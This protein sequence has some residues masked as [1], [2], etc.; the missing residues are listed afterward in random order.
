M[1]PFENAERLISVF[2]RWPSFHDAEI[3]RI[4]LERGGPDGPS[5]A[6]QIHV[7]AMT[8]EV[9]ARGYY[10]SKNHTLTTLRFCRIRL[11]ELTDFNHQNVIFDLE[12]SEIDPPSNEG[13]RFHVE[14]GTSYGCAF[15]LDCA[16]IVVDDVQPYD[17]HP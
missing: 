17:S 13:R 9:D 6:A 4:A 10:G 7:F 2:G 5:L 3:V 8:P 12:V 16:R 11:R 15:G 14:V 1:T